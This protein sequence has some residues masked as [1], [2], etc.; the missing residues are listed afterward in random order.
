V[1]SMAAF[2]GEAVKNGRHAAITPSHRRTRGL[3]TNSN[4]LIKTRSVVKKRN[5]RRP[6]Y[7]APGA[8]HHQYIAGLFGSTGDRPATEPRCRMTLPK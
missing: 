3:A 2:D 1:R 6:I 4:P 7:N 8:C 5:W